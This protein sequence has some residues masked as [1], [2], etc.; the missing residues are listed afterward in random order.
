MTRHAKN[1]VAVG[2][3]A[4]IF[5]YGF[6]AGKYRLPPH[7]Q[8]VTMLRY[9]KDVAG[10]RQ[11]Q[12]KKHWYQDT[13][14]KTATRCPNHAVVIAVLGQSNASNSVPHQNHPDKKLPIFMAFNGRCYVLEDPILGTDNTLGSIWPSFALALHKSLGK[15]IVIVAGA[16]SNS[17]VGDW[18]EMRTGILQRILDQAA[19]LYSSSN[20]SVDHVIWLQGESDA[21]QTQVSDRDIDANYVSK[22]N[23]VFDTLAERIFQENKPSFFVTTTSVCF[24]TLEGNQVI[25]DSQKR[26]IELRQDTR[27]AGDTDEIG[28]SGRHDGCHFNRLGAESVS[29]MLAENFLMKTK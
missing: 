12:I 4:T 3:I 9:A 23:S 27:F 8:I 26:I 19:N 11:T 5:L 17:R 24:D 21:A 15:P 13:R 7:D 2:L 28:Q 29:K 14:F 18:S 1:I 6:G 16:A 10:F 25:R 22:L 20:L